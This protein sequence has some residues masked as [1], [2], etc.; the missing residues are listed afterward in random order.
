MVNLSR[1]GQTLDRPCNE[2]DKVLMNPNPIGDGD[3]EGCRVQ[4]LIPQH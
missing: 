2:K 3:G 4:V 1:A